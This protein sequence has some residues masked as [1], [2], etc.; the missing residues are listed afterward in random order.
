MFVYRKGIFICTTQCLVLLQQFFPI[1]LDVQLS[2][3]RPNIQ[4]EDRVQ[5]AARSVRK[6]KKKDFSIC[7][8]LISYNI[9]L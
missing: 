5:T 7:R 1:A 6:L 2:S 9:C 4:D 3:E 8:F